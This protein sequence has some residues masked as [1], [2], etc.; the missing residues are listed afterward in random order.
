MRAGDA[1]RRPWR[2]PGWSEYI[3]PGRRQRRRRGSERASLERAGPSLR[4]GR[5]G[6]G[7]RQREAGRPRAGGQRSAE[8][9][10]RAHEEARGPWAPGSSECG[11]AEPGRARGGEAGQGLQAAGRA[12]DLLPGP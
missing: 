4:E 1:R 10:P 5:K 9:G 12:G 7:E 3:S 6:R 8:R 2:L 11:R